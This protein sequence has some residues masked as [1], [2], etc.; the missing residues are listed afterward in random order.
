M[1]HGFARFF[2]PRGMTSRTVCGKRPISCSSCGWTATKS[3]GTADARD[4]LVAAITTRS[5]APEV[6]IAAIVLRASTAIPAK[7]RSRARAV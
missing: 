6:N 2:N 7:S 3:L 1:S 4:A 5:A